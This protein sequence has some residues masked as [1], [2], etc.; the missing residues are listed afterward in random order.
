MTEIYTQEEVIEV[1]AELAGFKVT[2]V[3]QGYR[4]EPIDEDLNEFLQASIA[5]QQHEAEV[6]SAIGSFLGDD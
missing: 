3:F 5:E 6:C 4:I 1:L 2:R